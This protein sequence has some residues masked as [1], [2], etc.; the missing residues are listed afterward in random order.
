MSRYLALV[1]AAVRSATYCISSSR[2]SLGARKPGRTA[3]QRAN[4]C[5]RRTASAALR[6]GASP[7]ISAKESERDSALD[8]FFVSIPLLLHLT[9]LAEYLT[10]ILT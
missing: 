1:E 4:T 8:I 5:R 3:S 6:R 7:T 9:Y 10:R 2:Q